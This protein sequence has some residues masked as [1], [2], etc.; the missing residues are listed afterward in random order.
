MLDTALL[1]LA[2]SQHGV[3]ARYQ[4]SR[5]L[6][7]GQVEHALASAAVERVERGVYRLR[8]A[9]R[10]PLQP[11][12]AASLRARPRATATGPGVL[13][14]YGFEG[15]PADHPIAVVIAPERRITRVSFATRVDV[16]P[17]RPV[18]RCGE[19]R[20]ASPLDAYLESSAALDHV[21]ERP[22]RLGWDRLRFVHGVDEG[23]LRRR[24]RLLAGATPEI[25]RLLAALEV[26]GIEAESEMERV[27]GPLLWRFDP[28]PEPQAT[29]ATGHRADWLFRRQRV[30]VEYQGRV[31]HRGARNRRRDGQRTAALR[32]EDI[33]VF[34][35][36]VGDLD[37]G[38]ALLARLAGI[39]AL[40]SA[41]LG[42][43]P[44]RLR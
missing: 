12:I 24:A 36:E 20:L 14:T 38:H 30:A 34:H 32:G 11:M 27:L 39:L 16:D 22:F 37:D 2:E 8:G 41:Q 10:T 28:P 35:V 1:S 26:G 15:F 43:A 33:E 40:R 44:P 29:L 9:P 19:A 21:G 6:R 42:V 5:A 13:A 31:D 7:P 23:R 4:L 25:T 18:Q 3:L 17:E